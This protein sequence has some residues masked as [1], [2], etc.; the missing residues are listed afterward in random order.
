MAPKPAAPK[1]AAAPVSGPLAGVNSLDPAA[2]QAAIG[3]LEKLNHFEVLG[4]K[5]DAA[6]PAVKVAYLQLVRSFHPDTTPADA[7]PPVRPLREQV[8]ARINDANTVLSDDAAR[9][10]YLDEL[11]YGGDEKV[12]VAR[13]FQAED[14]FTKGCI[15]C[16]A[17]KYTDALAMFDQAIQ[18]ND[19][20][21][22][23]HAWRAWAKFMVAEDKKAALAP[24]MKGVEHALKLMPRCAPAAFFAGSMYKLLADNAQAGKWFKKC[25]ELDPN[26]ADAERELRYLK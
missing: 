25:L 12:D 11:K 17:R 7:P 4:L 14:L 21:A 2:L 20:E 1:P 24:A 3:K 22:E 13:I 10:T 23:F 5:Q 26:Y 6:A 16:K 19:Q 8:F 15:V 9:A 18:L